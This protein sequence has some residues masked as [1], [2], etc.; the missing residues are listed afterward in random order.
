MKKANLTFIDLEMTG[1]DPGKHEIIEMACVVVSQPDLSMID[2]WEKK[3][4]P[5]R[6][7]LAEPD[8]LRINNYSSNL[9]ADAVSLDEAMKEFREV[10]KGSTICGWNVYFDWLFLVKAFDITGGWPEV[11]YHTLD[12][13]PIAYAKLFDR[14]GIERFS[15]GEIAAYLGVDRGKAHTALP[16]A[17]ATFE[18]YKKLMQL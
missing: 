7:D 18:V 14:T 12:V 17:I 8:A 13:L 10:V 16:D 5:Q 1:T 9:W 6:I 11:H 4:K 15:L 3:V 2:T